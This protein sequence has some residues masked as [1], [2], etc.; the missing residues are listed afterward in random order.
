MFFKK[1]IVNFFNQTLVKISGLTLL[2]HLY[3]KKTFKTY[4]FL[5]HCTFLH[6]FAIEGV[7][8]CLFNAFLLNFIIM[9][10]SFLNENRD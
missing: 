2:G 1:Q 9:Q 3:L 5:L 7:D 10:A 6:W 4:F 8:I